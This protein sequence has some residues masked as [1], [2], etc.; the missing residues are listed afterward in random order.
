MFETTMTKIKIINYIKNEFKVEEIK[1]NESENI[2]EE[3]IKCFNP[4]KPEE[5]FEFNPNEYIMENE[6][7]LWDFSEFKK[8]FENENNFSLYKQYKN[9]YLFQ[10]EKLEN[11]YKDNIFNMLKSQ[12]IDKIFNDFTE[13]QQY[14]NPFKDKKIKILLN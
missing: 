5:Y 3:K 7:I 2:L 4:D 10:N 11:I 14:K 13:Y 8:Q 9:N 12:I 6:D 1:S